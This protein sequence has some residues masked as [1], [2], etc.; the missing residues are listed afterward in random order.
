MHVWMLGIVNVGEIGAELPYIQAKINGVC[1]ATAK[2][3]GSSL[4]GV[5]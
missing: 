4:F 2:Q 5:G 1:Q 3:T